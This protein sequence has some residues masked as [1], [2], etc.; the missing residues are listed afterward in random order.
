MSRV[1]MRVDGFNA[2]SGGG[3]SRM[4]AQAGWGGHSGIDVGGTN[5]L[6][7]GGIDRDRN[8]RGTDSR[9]MRVGVESGKFISS[10]V[11]LDGNGRGGR[12]GDVGEGGSFSSYEEV[13]L[14]RICS[15]AV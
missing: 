10:G 6:L 12:A 4:G 8:F 2:T 15:G 5:V 11:L 9:V 3:E 14:F 13:S 7:R 1:I